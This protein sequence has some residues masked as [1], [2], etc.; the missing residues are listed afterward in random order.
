MD[1]EAGGKGGDTEGVETGVVE[2][3]A[4]PATSAA[5]RGIFRAIA[6]KEEEE[7]VEQGVGADHLLPAAGQT[8][9][10]NFVSSPPCHCLLPCQIFSVTIVY[11]PPPQ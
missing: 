6:L 5:R 8:S 1:T 10:T 7:V 9:L 2:V 4:V 11:P 3:V